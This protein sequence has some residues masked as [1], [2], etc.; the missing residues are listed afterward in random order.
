MFRF[1]P[2]SHNSSQEL[3]FPYSNL[4]VIPTHYLSVDTLTFNL[5]GFH[6]ADYLLSSDT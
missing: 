6:I 3:I 1:Y 4:S 2:I 5:T